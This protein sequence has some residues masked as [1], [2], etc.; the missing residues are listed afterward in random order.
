MLTRMAAVN[1]AANDTTGNVQTIAGAAEEIQ[2]QVAGVAEAA[3]ATN[4]AAS[5]LRA[6][7]VRRFAA[8]GDGSQPGNGGFLRKDAYRL[9]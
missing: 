8:R 1:D 4:Q 6:G 2:A 9:T 3:E 5:A 7:C